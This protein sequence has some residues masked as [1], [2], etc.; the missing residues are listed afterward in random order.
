M[1]AEN[2]AEITRRLELIEEELLKLKK[3]LHDLRLTACELIIKTETMF[4][5]RIRAYTEKMNSPQINSITKKLTISLQFD[6][7]KSAKLNRILVKAFRLLGLVS[8]PLD[9]DTLK[10]LNFAGI[11]FRDFREF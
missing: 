3:T 2:L 1:L 7:I 4:I 5:S 8:L 6:E 10:V 11:K 9:I